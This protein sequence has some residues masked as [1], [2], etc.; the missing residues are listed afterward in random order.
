LLSPFCHPE[1]VADAA[2]AVLPRG[3]D[4]RPRSRKQKPQAPPRRRWLVAAALA[5]FGLV[6]VAGVVTY[7]I[8]T[9]EGELVIVTQSDDVKVVVEQG[10]KVVDIIDTKTNNRLTL[11]SGQYELKLKGAKEGLKLDLE[12]ATLTRGQ[13]VLAKV[14]R[15]GRGEQPA[16]PFVAAP[17]AVQRIPWDSVRFLSTCISHDDQYLMAS[18]M[19]VNGYRTAI[20]NSDGQKITE[21]G[22]YCSFFLP[23]SHD[24]LV[25]SDKHNS[26]IIQ[27]DLMAKAQRRA[28][29]CDRDVWGITERAISPHGQWLCILLQGDVISAKNLVTDRDSPYVTTLQQS[30]GMSPTPNENIGIFH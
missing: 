20:W 24:F 2:T 4:R 16:R 13:E 21:I 28:W 10:G 5:L 25:A 7:R 27:Y 8:Q 22:G 12:K 18:G 29:D 30:L 1:G 3:A 17:G 14:E 9:D 19:T 26:R 11:K 6:T 15:V 23:D